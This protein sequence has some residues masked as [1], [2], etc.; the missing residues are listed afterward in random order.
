[1]A[2]PESEKHSFFKRNQTRLLGVA[3]ILL[4]VLPYALYLL[5]QSGQGAGVGILI[6]LM[7]FL[8][9]GIILIT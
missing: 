3:F 5:A 4:L 1:M 9:V 2:K 8:M 6:A 7:A